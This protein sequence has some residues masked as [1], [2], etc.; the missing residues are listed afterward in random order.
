MGLFGTDIG[1]DW[2]AKKANTVHG[3]QDLGGSIYG[4]ILGGAVG[5]D[6]FTGNY[7]SA[8]RR[9]GIGGSEV[10][11]MPST[12][13]DPDLAKGLAD[14]SQNASKSSG[15][16]QQD[17]LRGTG[18]AASDLGFDPTSQALGSRAKRAFQN[19]AGDLQRQAEMQGQSTAFKR[20]QTAYDMQTQLKNYARG[21]DSQIQQHQID[22][23]KAR[24]AAMGSV[25]AGVGQGLGYAAGS[26]RGSNAS[27]GGQ[28]MGNGSS[29]NVYSGSN[30]AGSGGFNASNVG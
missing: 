11:G 9:L 25:F 28:S 30:S 3:A 6:V 23:E 22:A 1:P 2:D 24:S 5:S 20:Q 27:S 17:L 14:Y 10:P 12:P 8:M 15:Q 7:D 26:Y 13:M 4:G 16:I 19:S 29:T 21:I 18:K